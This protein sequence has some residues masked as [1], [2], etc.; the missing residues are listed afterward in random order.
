VLFV[1]IHGLSGRVHAHVAYLGKLIER[2]D[3]SLAARA[4]VL[5]TSLRRCGVDPVMVVP[6]LDASNLD[7][8]EDMAF[9]I[10]SN[11]AQS[12]LIYR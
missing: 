12:V 6:A 8:P 5:E 3:T 7:A 10:M 11:R 9:S 4:A 2:L 1:P